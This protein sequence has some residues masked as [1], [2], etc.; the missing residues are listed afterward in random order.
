MLGYIIL[1]ILLR[2]T[3]FFHVSVLKYKPVRSYWPLDEELGNSLV[4]QLLLVSEQIE[5]TLHIQVDNC[6]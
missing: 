4:F 1:L 3:R 2:I 6:P 5:E